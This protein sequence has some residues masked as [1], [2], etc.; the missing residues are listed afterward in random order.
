MNEE[1]QNRYRKLAEN[2]YKTKIKGDVTAQEIVDALIKNAEE[3]RPDYFRKLKNAL[4]FDQSEKGYKKA[5]KKITETKNPVTQKGSKLVKKPKEKRVKSINDSDLEKLL[6]SIRGK[7]EVLF[8]SI[9]IAEEF[10]CRPAELFDIKIHEGN[11][12]FIRGAKKSNGNRGLDRIIE[13]EEDKIK[14]LTIAIESLQGF[15]KDNKDRKSSPAEILQARLALVTK[16]LWPRRQ[17]RASFYTFRHQLGSDLKSSG[18]NRSEIAY[19]MGH[20]ATKSVDVYGDKRSAGASKVTIKAGVS[21]TKI[22]TVVRVNHSA[23]PSS[24]P[25]APPADD[26]MSF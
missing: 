4:A 6:G 1:T 3:Y 25:S 19:L 22:A 13:V 2:F 10:G 17:A 14:G 8:A 11:K 9:A 18:M 7:D 20:Q 26:G 16:R 12:I 21:A 15:K 24:P 23:P 5:V